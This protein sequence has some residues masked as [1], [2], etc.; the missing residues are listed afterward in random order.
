MAEFA[1]WVAIGVVLLVTLFAPLPKSFRTD[2]KPKSYKQRRTSGAMLGAVNE[3]FHPSA[4]NAALIMEQ[5]NEA[6]RENPSPED[7][8]GADPRQ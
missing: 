2:V 1:F 5:K 7:K 4:Q 8:P 3:V 6:G